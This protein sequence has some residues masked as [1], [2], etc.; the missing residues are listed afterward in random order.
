MDEIKN[1]KEYFDNSPKNIQTFLKSEDFQKL[2][3]ETGVEFDLR[4]SK[5][6]DLKNEILFVLVGLTERDGFLQSLNQN[7]D[8]PKELTGKIA[9]HIEQTIFSKF[10][11]ELK[12]VEMIHTE[13]DR[14]IET[15]NVPINLPVQEEGEE[16]PVFSATEKT[17]SNDKFQMIKTKEEIVPKT[18]YSTFKPNE[19][20][21]IKVQ[22]KP[23][24]QH[25]Q[26][27]PTVQGLSQDDITQNHPKPK[28]YVPPTR[29]FSYRDEKIGGVNIQKEESAEIDE[30]INREDLLKDIENPTK[31]EPSGGNL[32]QSS[33][34]GTD[35]YREPLE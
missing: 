2:I 8:L 3:N 28:P 29:D 27:T 10:E 22:S 20:P 17:M 12:E 33:Y 1:I 14:E 6:I 25:P 16:I 21:V 32:R 35:P 11:T 18:Q 15:E 19:I 9:Q 34:K 30:N 24:Y 13:V 7:L 23:Q 31:S 4:P 26:S 5:V